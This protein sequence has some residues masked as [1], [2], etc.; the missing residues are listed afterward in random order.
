M[1]LLM[2]NGAT[3]DTFRLLA[4]NLGLGQPHFENARATV[5]IKYTMH[6]DACYSLATVSIMLLRRFITLSSLQGADIPAT[7]Y[8]F[9]AVTYCYSAVILSILPS[10]VNH[11]E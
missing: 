3:V 4:A 2:R 6:Y 5:D 8:S 11:P 1:M 9:S 10:K 7:C